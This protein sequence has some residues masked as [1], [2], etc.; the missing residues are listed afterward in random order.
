MSTNQLF[1]AYCRFT[2]Q[3]CNGIR[4]GHGATESAAR[5]DLKKTMK[6]RGYVG[7]GETVVRVVD[8]NRAVIKE[9]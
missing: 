7:T 6:Y 3:D 5:D 2:S 4:Y 9:T 1:E 8:G